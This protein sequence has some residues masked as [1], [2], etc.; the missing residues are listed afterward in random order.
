MQYHADGNANDAFVKAE[1]VEIQET[2]ALEQAASRQG[3]A[4]FLQ[5]K[6]NRKRLLLIVLTT[7]FSQCSGNGIASYYLHDILESVGVTDPYKQSLVNGGLQI[8][9]FLCAIGFAFL[10]DKLGRRKLFLTAAIGM[11]LTFSVWTGCSAVYQQ[12]G[13]AAAGG[14]VIAMIFL[15][16]LMAGFAWPGLTVS[17]CSEILPFSIRAK[18]LAIAFAGQASASVL[19]QVRIIVRLLLAFC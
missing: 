2:I 12:T 15:F 16:Y 7:F 5:T 4:V 14:V 1:L 10:V 18:G 9:S 13:N 6:G 11:L 17:Y 3:W 19:N 8:W